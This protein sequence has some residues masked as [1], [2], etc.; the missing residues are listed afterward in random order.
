MKTHYRLPAAGATLFRLRASGATSTLILLAALAA[1]LLAPLAAAAAD[2]DGGGGGEVLVVRYAC[3]IGGREAGTA[4]TSSGVM[5]REELVD[6]LLEWK[7]QADN[8]EVRQVFALNDLGELARHASQ[9]PLSGGSI[10]GSFAHGESSFEIGLRIRPAYGMGSSG[11]QGMGVRAERVDSELKVTAEVRR[12]GELLSGPTK[13]HYH[14]GER[15]IVTFTRGPEAPF[16]FLVLEVDRMSAEELE[17]R[18]LRYSWSK[19]IR[20]V[21][22]EEVT[23]PVA[24]EKTPPSYPEEGRKAKHQGR[25]VLRT[26]I[27]E[28]GLVKDVE[29]I[30][31]QPFG[32]SEAAMAAVRTWRFQPALYDGE[33]VAVI[34]LLTI[35][36]RL[37]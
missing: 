1:A 19:D 2:G 25:V 32:L 11:R 20:L 10:S 9:L 30:E 36:F 17:R 4:P 35:N 18:G 33:P 22:G 15:T 34:Y 31:G 26:V 24:I 13:I 23:A 21:D 3:L 14:L 27:D 8:A 6:F 16:L 7:P 29:V 28:Q 5:S 37:E 12:G